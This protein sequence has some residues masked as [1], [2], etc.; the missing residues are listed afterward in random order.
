MWYT[1]FWRA[2]INT[3]KEAAMDV[4]ALKARLRT[5]LHQKD[6]LRYERDSLELFDLMVEI[7]REIEELHQKLRMTA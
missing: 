7:D 4:E 1:V 6:M 3:Q 2:A 5:L